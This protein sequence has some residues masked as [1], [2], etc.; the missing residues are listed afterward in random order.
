LEVDY[1]PISFSEIMKKFKIKTL[2]QAEKC[3]KLWDIKNG[4]LICLECHK[5][6]DNFRGKNHK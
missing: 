6:T 2:K 5:K 4:R 3:D 1:Y